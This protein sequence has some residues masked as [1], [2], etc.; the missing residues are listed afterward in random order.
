MKVVKSVSDEKKMELRSVINILKSLNN[1]MIV[2]YR[3]SIKNK[4]NFHV[5]MDLE[6]GKTIYIYIYT[7]IGNTLAKDIQIRKMKNNPYMLKEILNILDQL[8]F[9]IK[10]L[11]NNQIAHYNLKP[12]NIFLTKDFNLKIGDFGIATFLS[13]GDYK[14]MKAASAY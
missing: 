14:L 5:F 2:K 11:H 7:L 9:G 1:P 12:V 10:Y 6:T 4:D 13:I 8:L 3:D